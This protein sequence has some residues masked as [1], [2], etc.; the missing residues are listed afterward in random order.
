M[1]QNF[2]GKR[3]TRVQAQF[4]KKPGTWQIHKKDELCFHRTV[5]P[6]ENFLGLISFYIKE[7]LGHIVV[8]VPHSDTVRQKG[9]HSCFTAEETEKSKLIHTGQYYVSVLTFQQLDELSASCI[10]LSLK[11][12]P[13]VQCDSFLTKDNGKQIEF[14]RG[15]LSINQDQ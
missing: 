11:E 12:F 4:N 10:L 9:S 3:T 1:E 6:K 14:C 13:S 7:L 2:N 5:L 8:S 15:R